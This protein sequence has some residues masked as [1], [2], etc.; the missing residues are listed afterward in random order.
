MRY[1]F[2]KLAL[3]SSNK[4][5]IGSDIDIFFFRN[6][7]KILIIQLNTIEKVVGFN[8]LLSL[9]SLLVGFFIDSSKFSYIHKDITLMY[10]TDYELVVWLRVLW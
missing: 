10:R 8:L 7:S 6:F 1:P 9:L 5:L 2:W 4:L 3:T